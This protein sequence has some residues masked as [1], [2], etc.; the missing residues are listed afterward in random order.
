M[1][2]PILEKFE[3]ILWESFGNTVFLNEFVRVIKT[4]NKHATKAEEGLPTS[5]FHHSS[6]YKQSCTLTDLTL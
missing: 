2:A 3:E 6:R 1:V 4:L 5:D